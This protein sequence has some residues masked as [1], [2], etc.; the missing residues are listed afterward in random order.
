MKFEHAR[1]V[2]LGASGFIGRWVA[3]AIPESAEKYLFVRDRQRSQKMFNDY[4]IQGKQIQIDLRNISEIRKF[5]SDLQPSI[6][7]NFAGYGVDP[8]ERDP[9]LFTLMNGELPRIL[10]E[11][12]TKHYDRAWIGSRLIHAGTALEYG[13]ATGL[14]SEEITAKPSTIYGISKY[15]GSE[16]VLRAQFPAIV[17]RLFNVYGPGE[18]NG[19]LLPSL[20]ETA[21]SNQP[22]ALT[23]GTQKRDFTYVE[24][25]A[26]GCVRLSSIS[27]T[28][29]RLINLATGNLHTVRQFAEVAAGALGIPL[30]NLRFGERPFRSD[31]MDH[32]GVSTE[33]LRKLI[34]WTPSTTIEQGVKRTILFLESFTK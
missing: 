6:V 26:E 2:V 24:D 15:S 12:L 25:V 28:S 31:E 17:A 8:Q 23:A 11:L 20:I 14:L 27:E 30:N 32:E 10:C 19:R 33:R 21:K 1:V 9:H 5:L 34:K 29:P 4:G 22:L 7:F 16:T 13:K 3:R 18:H